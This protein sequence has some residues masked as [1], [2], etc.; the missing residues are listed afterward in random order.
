MQKAVRGTNSNCMSAPANTSR[1]KIAMLCIVHIVSATSDLQCAPLPVTRCLCLSLLHTALVHTVP[2]PPPDAKAVGSDCS[3][4]LR[5]SYHALLRAVRVSFVLLTPYALLFYACVIANK[6][7]VAECAALSDCNT[8]LSNCS[9][10]KNYT[11]KG[12]IVRL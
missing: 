4:L 2:L 10:D 9:F 8:P 5:L 6:M 11:H 7:T 12:Y 3:S 1:F